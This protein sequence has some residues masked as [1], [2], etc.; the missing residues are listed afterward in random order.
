MEMMSNKVN[1]IRH[2][3][4]TAFA[5]VAVM[6]VAPV[7]SFA[8]SDFAKGV[9]NGTT[10]GADSVGADKASFLNKLGTLYASIVSSFGWL[11]A[12]ICIGWQL[13]NLIFRTDTKGVQRWMP[14]IILVSF[15][16][17]GYLLDAIISMTGA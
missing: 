9:T 2:A 16:G 8:A 14:L 13:V 5:S 17:L 15:Y 12:T 4:S 1:K 10:L 11:V 7:T 3:V 6:L